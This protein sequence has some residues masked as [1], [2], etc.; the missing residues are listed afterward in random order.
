MK[1]N[2]AKCKVLNVG[3]GNPKHRYKLVREWLESSPEE[4]D[5]GVLGDKKL[6]M[7]QQRAVSSGLT[8]KANRTL[9]C[10]KRS[11][12]SRSR[13]VILPLC[14]LETPPGVLHPALE[15]PS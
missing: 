2:K 3:R 7:S 8:Q 6:N 1:F 12:A 13:E 15:P 9:G 11:M 4:K 5:L 14:S 10:I